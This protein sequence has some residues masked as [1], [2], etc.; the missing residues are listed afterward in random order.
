M[1]KDISSRLTA[2]F[3]DS[4]ITPLLIL[5]ALFIGILALVNLPRE[6][7]PQINVPL[8]D[9]FVK[10]DGLKAVDGVE[11]VTKPLEDIIRGIDEVEHTYSFTEDDQALVTARFLVGTDEDK[12]ILRVHETIRAHL[13]EIPHG[14]TMPLIVGRGINDVPILVINLLPKDSHKQYWSDST[15]Y[16]IAEQMIH[17]L[18]KIDDI[19]LSFIV[20][21]HPIQLQI[22][23]LPEKLKLYGISLV[24]LIEKI[25]ALNQVFQTQAIRDHGKNIP[26]VTGQTLQTLGQIENILLTNLAG[27]QIYLSDVANVTLASSEDEQ[28][29]FG[30]RQGETE[31]KPAVSIAIAKRKGA[32]AVKV[33]NEVNEVMALGENFKQQ[34]VP[35][36]LTMEVIR[37]YGK[38]AQEKSDGLLFNLFAAT[39]TI[40]VLISLMVGWREGVTVFVIIPITILLTLAWSWWLGFTINRVSLFALIFSIGILVDDA[41]VITDNIKRYWKKSQNNLRENALKAVAEIGNP[42]IMAN[43]TIL[44]ALV[45]MLFVTGL[46]GPYMSPIPTNASAAVM[47]SLFIALVVAPW[48]MVRLYRFSPPQTQTETKD[49]FAVVYQKLLTPIIQSK[50]RALFF[51]LA[52]LLITL[53]FISFFY[54]KWVSVKMLPFDNKP[55]LQLVVDLPTNATAEQTERTLRQLAKPLTAFDDIESLWFYVGTAAP[56]NF[57][58]L[59]RHYYLR[60]QPHQGEIFI[61]LKENN[62]RKAK[63]HKIALQIRQ[64]IKSIPVPE[65]TRLKLVEVPPGPPVIAS[66]LAEIY[67]D[68]ESTRRE[69]ADKVRG[70]FEQI[71]FVDD[72]DVSYGLRG[73]RYR[74]TLDE[75]QIEYFGV[76]E[77]NILT[78]IKRLF[79]PIT[80]GYSHR[81]HGIAPVEI[82]MNL[83]KSMRQWNETILSTPIESQRGLIELGDVVQIH[84]EQ[85]SY[86]YYRRNGQFTDFVMGELAGEFEAPIYGIMAVNEKLKTQGLEH[87]AIRYAGQPKTTN[88]PS[89]LWDGEWE[90]TY[91]TFRDLGLAFI[92]AI[93]LI[94]MLLVAESRSFWLP[95]LILVPIPLTLSGIIFGHWIL[96]A[97]FT[98][99]SMIGFIALAGIIIRNSLLLIEFIRSHLTSMPIQEALISAG[100][101]RFRPIFLTAIT[102]MIG[103][104]FML[105]DP[106]FE[107]LGIS[108]FFGL[109]SSTFLTILVI[110]ALFY[111]FHPISDTQ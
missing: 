37:N 49:R 94:Y 69:I 61:K 26:L 54:L 25:E 13:N 97:H 5:A 74:I 80:L 29:V 101:I 111:I 102:A 7:E 96:G 33:V 45:P 6:E 31:F 47:L 105:A 91:V 107:G 68:D 66:L 71:P 81:G 12:A 104:L 21:G 3:I 41:I 19:A 79:N 39:V 15:L 84:P 72:V 32:N 20:G 88:Q 10:V 22:Q 55:E 58:G 38:T 36:S 85:T 106:I 90:I 40:V 14:I 24:Q 110:P 48:M 57:N 34:L 70:I 4:P 44:A 17:E 87:L 1:N 76:D 95:I 65:H 50:F 77:Q 28:S 109:A 11:L 64:K 103:A 99:T 35:E 78:T 59:V 18:H 86:P 9:I 100:G 43:L 108:L 51:L 98:A 92:G 53:Y 42:T 27:K 89:L 63:S 16:H 83:P 93:V 56:Y 2:I 8:V 67:A 46:M 75:A 62:Q 82:V 60:N 30:Q 73:E 52:V 23:P